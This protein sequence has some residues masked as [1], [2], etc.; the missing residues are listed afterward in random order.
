MN[1]FRPLLA[2]L[3][4]S[5]MLSATPASSGVPDPT[6]STAA[7]VLLVC[8]Q[9]DAVFRVVSRDFANNTRAGDVVMLDFGACPTFA[10]CA[11]QT[12]APYTLDLVHHRIWESTDSHGIADFP[13]RL[14]G[15]C[16]DSLVTVYDE[17]VPLARRSVVSPDQNGDGAVDAADLALLQ[18]KLGTSAPTGDFDGDGIV[19]SADIALLQQHMGHVCQAATPVRPASWGRLKMLYR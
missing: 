1:R 4:V 13:I 9:G 12:G 15:T 16:P 3:A 2:A 6:S 14:G 8:P 7:P 11:D 17:G 5:A 19:T 10:P 18:A